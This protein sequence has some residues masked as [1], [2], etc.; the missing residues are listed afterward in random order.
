MS[1]LGFASGLPYAIANETSSA[2]LADLKIDRSTIGLLGAIGVLYS[3]KFLWSP[4]IDARAA[5]GLER[6]GRR[7]SWL[8]ATQL[9]LAALIAC[10]GIVAPSTATSPLTLFAVLLVAIAFLSATLD[11]VVNAWTVDSFSTPELGI[12]SSMSVTGYR[13]ALLAGGTAALHLAT[14]FGWPFAFIAMGFAMAIGVAAT[15][16]S[17]E[18]NVEMG[19]SAGGMQ[20]LFEPLRE[21][22]LRLCT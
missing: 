21:L 9:P 6:L 2:L 13:I 12:G 16:L 8:L 22:F 19:P 7:R 17:R 20:S 3:F 10:L 11:I 5:P 1:A 18:P 14:V 15:I 4:L